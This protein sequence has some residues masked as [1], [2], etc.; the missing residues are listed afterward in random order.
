MPAR[1][2]VLRPRWRLSYRSS[3]EMLGSKSVSEIAPA[4]PGA[5]FIY[6]QVELEALGAYATTGRVR[7]KDGP[8]V[9]AVDMFVS[10]KIRELAR[11]INDRRR[12][13]QDSNELD[14]VHRE[15]RVLDR[16]KNKFMP[17][18]GF[19]GD[20][21]RGKNSHG[22]G[23]QPPQPPPPI[24]Y[25]TVPTVIE[26]GWATDRP[27][28]IGSGVSIRLATI[29]RIRVRDDMGLSVPGIELQWKIEDEQIARVEGG[30][31]KGRHGGSTTICARIAGTNICS[32][33][34]TLEIWV[35]DHVLLTP[36]TLE[37]ML[38]T[39]ETITAEVT[40]D[41][42]ERATDILLE[43]EHD[44]DDSL[45]VRISP[46]GAV[47]GNRV[48]RTSISA[49]ARGINDEPVW[50]RVRVDTEVKPNPEVPK[51]GSGFPQL[52]LTDRD[53]DP[54]TGEVRSGSPDSPT[55]WQDV[56]DLINNIWWL[57]LQSEDAA[58]AF[59]KRPQDPKFGRMFHAQQTVDM[60]VQVHMQQEFTAKG[61]EERPDLWLIHKQAFERNQ[62]N[63]K[64]A[65]WEE[66][67]DYVETGRGLE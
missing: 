25:G 4:T 42:G 36:R 52:L 58:F 12:H 11:Q 8:L 28:R 65:M 23:P 40:N 13:E 35:V 60:V 2:K 57:N 16:F 51:E 39:K 50:A 20:G 26:F 3:R 29:L 10:D 30:V 53:I 17:T 18:E 14:D 44:A 9:Q 24:E 54:F 62:I 64:Q 21:N 46:F 45:I 43:W 48:G 38:G 27:L 15:N 59:E 22:S 56:F 55:L 1:H 5:E 19:G 37:L 47:F 67:K 41:R 66:L 61:E 31:L 63:L 33:S 49:G 32:P 6:G 7:P 34:L